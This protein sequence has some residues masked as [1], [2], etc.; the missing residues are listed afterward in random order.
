[1]QHASWETIMRRR[2]QTSTSI[3]VYKEYINSNCVFKSY[4]DKLTNHLYDSHVYCTH[5]N[6]NTLA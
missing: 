3:S 4:N 2:P 5:V 6:G 1:M